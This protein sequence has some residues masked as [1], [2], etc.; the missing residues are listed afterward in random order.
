MCFVKCSHLFLRYEKKILKYNKRAK[1]SAFFLSKANWKEKFQ[2]WKL[3]ARTCDALICCKVVVV[4]NVIKIEE[5]FDE[6]WL[7]HVMQDVSRETFNLKFKSSP[8][9]PQLVLGK[10]FFIKLLELFFF[11]L[12]RMIKLTSVT[13]FSMM[14]K[15]EFLTLI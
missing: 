13:S 2:F 10:T 15:K 7:S 1:V 3:W 8:Y 4:Q 14:I 5:I 11:F 6:I 12:L 9:K